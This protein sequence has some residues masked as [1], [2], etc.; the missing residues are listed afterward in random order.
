[1]KVD[2]H[3][4]LKDLDGSVPHFSVMASHALLGI[5]ETDVIR[6][7]FQNM[8]LASLC[9]LVQIRKKLGRPNPYLWPRKSNQALDL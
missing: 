1:M 4:I 7:V 8:Y 2:R 9:D 3:P 5:W 6:N